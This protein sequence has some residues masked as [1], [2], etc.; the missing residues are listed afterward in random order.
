MISWLLGVLGMREDHSIDEQHQ[1]QA[2]FV[3]IYYR[4]GGGAGDHKNI[5]SFKCA[6]P[7]IIIARGYET[8]IPIF[9][10]SV[11]LFLLVKLGTYF[12]CI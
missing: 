1:L 7:F 12:G 3:I 4:G 5:Y 9:V 8:D 11:R 2:R 6:Y 10:V